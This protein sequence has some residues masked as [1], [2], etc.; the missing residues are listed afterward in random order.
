MSS[1]RQTMIKEKIKDCMRAKLRSYKPEVSNMPFHHR[2]LGKDRMALFSFI[3]S[4][5][6]KFGTLFYEPVAIALARG[7]FK[8]AET[9]VKPFNRIS[10]DAQQQVQTIMDE[11]WVAKRKP[12]RCIEMEEIRQVCQTGTLR[13]VKQTPVDIRLE[14]YDG[15]LFFIDLKPVKPSW[16]HIEGY[17][18]TLLERTAAELARNPEAIVNTMIGIP[19]NPYEPKLYERWTMKGMLDLNREVL[20]AEELWDF[21]GGEGSYADLLDAFEMAGIELRP[22]IDSY[23]EKFRYE[24]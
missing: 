12:N 8:V 23:F 3:H 24:S 6:T 9:Q 14:N 4:L 16:N 13:R 2:L 15:A 1:Q 18:R 21:L 5:N 17:K 11:L 7:R 20:I 10:P 22:E 19:Y